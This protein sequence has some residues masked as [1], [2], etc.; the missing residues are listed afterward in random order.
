[1]E[2]KFARTERRRTAGRSAVLFWQEMHGWDAA[3]GRGESRLVALLLFLSIVEGCCD[4]GAEDASDMRI[5]ER[6]SY[7]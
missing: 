4:N 6:N 1:M 7:R 3:Q 5:H 2:I